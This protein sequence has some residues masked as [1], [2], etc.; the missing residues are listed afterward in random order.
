M[1]FSD[2]IRCFPSEVKIYRREAGSFTKGR[3]TPGAQDT[4][5]T[6]IMSVQ[7][8]TG[9]ERLLLPEGVRTREVVKAY[10]RTLLRT[11]NAPSG[12]QADRIE[13]KDEFYEVFN[14]EDW[15]DHGDYYKVMAVKE[16]Q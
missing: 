2:I 15:S 12:H 10:C 4:I 16:G 9:D 11:D 3:Y 7:P 5:F 14:V 1:S 6:E 13:Y 8:V